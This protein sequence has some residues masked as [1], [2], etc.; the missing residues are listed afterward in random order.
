M[1]QIDLRS[2][3]PLQN[4]YWINYSN[5]FLSQTKKTLQE[6]SSYQKHHIQARAEGPWETAPLVAVLKR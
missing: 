2:S 1:L 6:I 4:R 3:F 5:D